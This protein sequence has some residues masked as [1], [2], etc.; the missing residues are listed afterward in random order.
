MTTLLLQTQYNVLLYY[1]YQWEQMISDRHEQ[2]PDIALTPA[3]PCKP[4]SEPYPWGKPDS[5]QCYYEYEWLTLSTSFTDES[6]NAFISTPF[7]DWD[8]S[9]FSWTL[10]ISHSYLDHILFLRQKQGRTTHLLSTHECMIWIITLS[11]HLLTMDVTTDSWQM[12]LCVTKYFWHSLF[13]YITK[14]HVTAPA[15]D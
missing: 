6:Q 2:V 11:H 8:T 5:Y 15:S 4:K 7:H 3:K 10:F 1:N 9:D 14:H 12:H 13:S